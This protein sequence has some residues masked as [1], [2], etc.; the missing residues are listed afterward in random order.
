MIQGS[1]G[2]RI[3]FAKWVKTQYTFTLTA[4]LN[5]ID[6]QGVQFILDESPYSSNQY[7]VNYGESYR[8]PIAESTG[9]MFEGWYYD[10]TQITDAQGYSITDFAFEE[11]LEIQ[12][13]FIRESYKIK[14]VINDA[15]SYWLIQDGISKD[16]A[17]IEYSANLCPNCMVKLL[18]NTNSE[19]AA[20]FFRDGYIYDCL[21]TV[22]GDNTKLACW[23]SFSQELVNGA[24]YTVYAYYIPE[25]YQ[26]YFENVS[27]ERTDYLF[28]ETIEYPV[29]PKKNGFEFLG[30]FDDQGKKFA[31]TKMPDLTPGTEGNGSISVVP[32]ENP[33]YYNINYETNGGIFS[34]GASRNYTV[35]DTTFSLP[36][37]KQEGY[38]FMGWYEKEDFV[39]NIITEIPQGS[40]GDK[41]FYARWEKE[42]E[43]KIFY[44]NN[45]LIE[46]Y[47]VITNESIELPKFDNYGP[48]DKT[49]YYGLWT[50]KKGTEILG[51]FKLSEETDWTFEYN[52]DLIL[53]FEWKGNIYAINYLHTSF[54]GQTAEILVDDIIGSHAPNTY[55][56]G[57]GLNLSNI[58]AYFQADSPYSPHMRFMGWYA[59]NEFKTRVT[60]IKD[61]ETGKVSLY[62]KWRY[63]QDNPSRYGTYT[64]TD[65]D[66]YSTEYYDQIYIGMQSN[67]LY[68]NLK[69]VGIKYLAIKLS[70]RMW[71]IDDGY[72]EILI[73]DGPNSTDCIWS[74]TEIEHGPGKVDKEHRVYETTIFIDIEKIKDCSYLYIRYGAHGNKTDNWQNDHLYLELMYTAIEDDSELSSPEFIWHYQYPF[75]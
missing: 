3:Y 35:I 57:V 31:Y 50:I 33:I 73:Y 52:F 30:W 66:P 2:N 8:L 5:L 68:S 20:L 41:T 18:K 48:K 39:G 54:M 25:L 58:T 7:T 1:T 4:D 37:P 36:T 17:F 28:N 60:K 71:E 51:T 61:T 29:Y 16:E 23:H 49:E 65:A 53:S 45:E 26:I 21:T 62:A 12:A 69:N 22:K 63:D 13:K 56:Y 14:L 32:K 75:D 19:Y 72:Q 34:E 24:E 15:I 38:R 67:N 27:G 55:E 11:N 43:L 46:R 42:Y 10:N 6:G 74:N 9:F 59:D 64:I 47:S 44:Q 40:T 70:L